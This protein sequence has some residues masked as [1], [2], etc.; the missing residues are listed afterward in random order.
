MTFALPMIEFLWG[1]QKQRAVHE[2]NV[3]MIE[4]RSN[5][6]N[7]MTPR[8]RSGDP[9]CEHAVS[10]LMANGAVLEGSALN[11]EESHA[12]GVTERPARTGPP[13][14][15]TGPAARNRAWTN[16]RM[17]NLPKCVD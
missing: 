1:R 14:I 6:A 10:D 2:E 17:T 9:P 5:P 4:L 16:S 13:S 12:R 7:S 11:V 3:W 15:G 8:L